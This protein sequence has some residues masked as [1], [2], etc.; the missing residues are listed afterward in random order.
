MYVISAKDIVVKYGNET[1]TDKLSFEIT[2]DEKGGYQIPD[3]T[4]DNHFC[5][6][7]NY[8]DT[9]SI[10]IKSLYF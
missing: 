4:D 10:Y 2:K 5:F 7:Y 1:I 3:N 8:G 9:Y 6:I